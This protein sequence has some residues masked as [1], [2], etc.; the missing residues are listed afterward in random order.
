MTFSVHQARSPSLSYLIPTAFLQIKQTYNAVSHSYHQCSGEWAQTILRDR[1]HHHGENDLMIIIIR[2]KIR[3]RSLSSFRRSVV[4]PPLFFSL[5]SRHIILHNFSN[6]LICFSLPR[7]V[8]ENPRP[9]S[10]QYD[11]NDTITFGGSHQP[12]FT[13]TVVRWFLMDICLDHESFYQVSLDNLTHAQNEV[14]SSKFSEW[15]KSELNLE[16]NRGYIVFQDPGRSHIGWDSLTICCRYSAPELK[17]TLCIGIKE[18]HLR[19]SSTNSH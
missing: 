18:L 7:N 2:F 6:N 19:V 3:K 4:S 14:Y 1:H 16:S 10:V 15:L 13:L 9:T 5:G 8:W 11:Y 17:W 12:A